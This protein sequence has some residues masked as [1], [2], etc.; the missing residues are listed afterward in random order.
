MNKNKKGIIALLIILFL[1]CL[2]CGFLG[3]FQN[4]KKEKTPE[5]PKEYVVNTIY[6]L[7]NVQV[8]E[9]PTNEFNEDGVQEIKYAF[10]FESTVC[11]NN[12]KWDWDEEKWTFTVNKTADST[13]RVYFVNTKFDITVRVTGGT[14]K[15]SDTVALR[16][17]DHIVEI[18]P[19]AGYTYSN[20]VCANNEIGTW[21]EKTNKLTIA[22]V[23]KTTTCDVLFEIEKYTV[24]IISENGSGSTTIEE[25]EYG[26]KVTSNVV[27][28]SGY[29]YSGAPVC[30]N[31]QTAT[32]I[33]GVLTI[34]KL[35]SDTVCTLTFTLTPVT[36]T[37]FTVKINESAHITVTNSS[38]KSQSV[39]D[40]D[41]V[42]VGVT[43]Q[44]GYAIDHVTCTSSETEISAGIIEIHNVTKNQICTIVEKAA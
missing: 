11:T 40:G 28:S 30:T 37:T 31:K 33:D 35:T 9:I 21:D 29:S 39:G 34:A 15:T 42:F 3:L 32:W 8:E 43:M 20:T 25:Q 22:S 7:D 2:T 12:V 27:A 14:L 38:D 10:D 5:T 6:Y 17:E 19:T 36:P 23:L 24:Q 44:D 16:G 13:C 4:T 26:S 1:A 18:K 41:N